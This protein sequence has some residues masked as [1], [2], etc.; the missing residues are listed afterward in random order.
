MPKFIGFIPLLLLLG[1]V[2]IE[3]A[4]GFSIPHARSQN[5]LPTTNQDLLLSIL[6]KPETASSSSSSLAFLDWN[7][8]TNP[9][10]ALGDTSSV[11]S[12]PTATPLSTPTSQVLSDVLPPFGSALY[13]AYQDLGTAWYQKDDNVLV[14]FPDETIRS[15]TKSTG[16]ETSWLQDKLAA[17][18]ISEAGAYEKYQT[19]YK[20]KVAAATSRWV[21]MEFPSGGV[22]KV[23]KPQ[24]TPS[25]GGA[26]YDLP[27]ILPGYE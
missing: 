2:I 25:V 14:I 8:S 27:T 20:A 10:L 11:Y 16:E 24:P 23:A 6:Q 13:Y 12:G 7:L 18:P 22:L 21:L 15:F 1:L 5:T 4:S 17:L 9:N 26:S 19:Q 3:T